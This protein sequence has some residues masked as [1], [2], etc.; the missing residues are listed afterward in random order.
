M[1]VR[2]W[3]PVEGNDIGD[4]RHRTVRKTVATLALGTI[5]IVCTSCGRLVN[6]SSW[7][8][9][10][11]IQ[12]AQNDER[13]S[14]N[15]IV[16]RV[17]LQP[18]T[19][20]E[21]MSE[22][23]RALQSSIDEASSNGGG[24]L[25]LPTGT[26]SF[27]PMDNNDHCAWCIEMKSNVRI[28][29]EG[30]G[31]TVLRPYGDYDRDYSDVMRTTGADITHG[32][33]MFHGQPGED[34]VLEDITAN[35]SF[36]G[37]RIDGYDT[38]GGSYNAGGKGFYFQGFENCKWN[39]VT[40]CN[41]DGTGF[42][43]DFP[44]GDCIIENCTAYGCGKN[45][46]V[47]GEGA[48]G[49]GIGT[50]RDGESLTIRNCNAYG[51]KKYGFFFEDQSRFANFAHREDWD[52]NGDSSFKVADCIAH[53]NKYDFGGE[54]AC[55]VEYMACT[56]LD[57][58][59]GANVLP[60]HF[61]NNSKNCK[62]T[63]CFTQRAFADEADDMSRAE[64]IGWCRDN[65]LIDVGE[66]ELFN[67][68]DDMTLGDALKMVWRASGRPGD[69]C[70]T[71]DD[72]GVASYY[73]VSFDDVSIT[74]DDELFGAADWYYHMYGVAHNG[75][76]ISEGTLDA[77]GSRSLHPKQAASAGDVALMLYNASGAASGSDG[78]A[79]TAPT[80]DKAVAWFNGKSKGF[81]IADKSASTRR[82]DVACMVETVFRAS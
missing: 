10:D 55:D 36:E 54:R 78:G 46:T 48:S 32:V 47:D 41:T 9:G 27:Y 12:D 18:G 72:N 74:D 80:I 7:Q 67:P 17:G 56:S 1:A 39:H 15:D 2:A 28:I 38:R 37:F 50:H 26:Y 16:I 35:C 34:G 20:A 82:G 30:E 24:T 44:Y 68:Y 33:D 23:S 73:P 76:R 64:A 75:D 40:V 79:P 61:G 45:A 31:K 42:G 11:V 3:L 65:G 14:V 4:N 63:D 60:F 52:D 49:F 57:D 21:V 13:E 8:S 5:M 53:G 19:S 71:E 59:S 51:N 81:K 69:F 6:E 22:N 77:D 62:V 58:G 70:D 66:D 43:V 29:G 25:M